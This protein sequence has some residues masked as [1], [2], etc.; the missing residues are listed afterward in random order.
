MKPFEGY[1]QEFV[2]SE[3]IHDEI[4]KVLDSSMNARHKN[5]EVSRTVRT[6]IKNGEDTGLQD[7][8]PKKGSSRA[9]YFP[10]EPRKVKID[11]IDTQMHTALKVAFPGT[12]DKFHGESTLLG[13]D[14]N[15]V[16]S[17][18]FIRQHYG[19]LRQGDDGNFQTNTERGILAPVISAHRDHSEDSHWI[20]FGKIQKPAAGEFK[21]LT[22]Y[23]DFPKGISHKEFYDAVNSDWANAHGTQHYGFGTSE[24]RVQ[25]LRDHPLVDK[26]LDMSYDTGMHPADLHMSNLGVWQ[27]P[28]TG[29]KHIVI[30][31]YGYSKGIAKKY[32]RARDKHRS[33]KWG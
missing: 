14:Q 22:K 25:A 2:L 5:T 3:E 11:G 21:E 16:E 10:S 30:S 31:D 4:K 15:Q 20:E 28:V 33:V 19:I 1:K 8:K 12:L 7:G 13:E 23:P 17:D 9:V 18:H 6:L 32:S 24:E 29:E 26:A 27:H